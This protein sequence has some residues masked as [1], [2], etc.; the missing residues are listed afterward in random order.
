MTRQIIFTIILACFYF[1]CKSQTEDEI[2]KFKLDVLEKLKKDLNESI[3]SS[4]TLTN[5]EYL[6]PSI[7]LQYKDSGRLNNGIKVGI[8]VEYSLDTLSAGEQIELS[9][10]EKK[11]LINLNILL[12]KE[13]G[14]YLNGK[15]DGIWIKYTSYDKKPPFYF[16]K[17]TE[18][19]YKA[20]LKNGKEINFIYNDTITF[21]TFVNGQIHG[22]TKTFYPYYPH[23]LQNLCNAINGKIWVIE[24]YYESGQLKIKY[25]DT[26]IKGKLYKHFI[27]Y[28]EMGNL[29][30]T[31]Y[32]LNGEQKFGRWTYYYENGNIES[33]T[34]YKNDMIDG[35]DKYYYDNGQL[36]TERIYKNDKLMNVN[37]IYNKRGENLNIGTIK[38]G[39]GI[40]N[41]YDEDG[42][43]S[44]IN[45]YISGEKK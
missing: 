8:W 33:I 12:E 5:I 31:G 4:N 3:D 29:K 16:K 9:V 19:N 28:Y 26:I 18:T 37:S 27:E 42:K 10:G 39:N 15:K 21:M 43:L 45:E 25:N 11:T 44:K 14:D 30:G 24:S 41:V 13:I 34:N 32:Y 36:W 1:S 7:I 20:G 22:I 17:S 38:D 40:L 35:Y 23:K 2:Q 6:D